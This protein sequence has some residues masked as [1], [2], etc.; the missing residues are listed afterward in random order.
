MQH[1]DNSNNDNK[2]NC[3]PLLLLLTP[4]VLCC[5]FGEIK[6][7]FFVYFTEGK[8]NDEANKIVKLLN[9]IPADVTLVVFS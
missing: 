1:K 4:A 3:D 2:M 9:A 6:L 7:Y 5:I 8:S